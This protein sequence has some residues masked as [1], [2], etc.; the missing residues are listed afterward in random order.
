MEIK[1]ENGFS[2]YES[3]SKNRDVII[4][5]HGLFG[6][7]SNFKDLNDEFCDN[8]KIVIPI[9]PLYTMKLKETGIQGFLKYLEKFIGFKEFHNFHLLGNSLGGHIALLYALKW[10]AKLATMTLTGSSG[11][12]ESGMG[13]G[14]PKRRNYDYIKRKTAETFYD[15]SVANKELVDEV[16]E[17]VNDREKALRIIVTAKSAL[18][19]N[20]EKMLNKISVPTL[21]IWGKN[22]TITPKFVGE[23]FHQ[24]IKSSELVLIDRCGHA[25]MMERPKE[26]NEALSDFLIRHKI[27]EG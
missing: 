5:L 11:L 22:D 13:D 19:N 26:F 2:Y 8:Y 4:L 21:L 18:R 15:P 24:L 14:Y 20:I 1:N 3:S 6:T 27:M 7:L 23:K 9:L 12:F 16:F 10:Q 17:I 25:P